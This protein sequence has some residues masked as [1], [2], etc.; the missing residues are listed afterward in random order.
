[1]YD[2]ELPKVSLYWTVSPD[3]LDHSMRQERKEK[4]ERK[5]Y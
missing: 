4:K 5:N 2:P 1:M 3:S